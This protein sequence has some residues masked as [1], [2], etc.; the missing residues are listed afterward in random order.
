MLEL[1]ERGEP[2][3]DLLLLSDYLDS[4]NKLK[5][6]GGSAYLSDLIN[7]TLTSVHTP[8]YARKVYNCAVLRDYIKAASVIAKTA[9]IE[10]PTDS[11][12]LRLQ[13]IAELEMFQAAPQGTR[14]SWQHMQEIVNA[15]LDRLEAQFKMGLS[16][17]F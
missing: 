4:K 2:H 12:L 11:D 1:R 10:D 17:V 6:I 9:Y 16:Q 14:G 7:H 13:E 8:W 3:G 5:E 15:N